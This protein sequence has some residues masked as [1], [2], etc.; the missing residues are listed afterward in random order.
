MPGQCQSCGEHAVI[1]AEIDG[2]GTKYICVECG[3]VDSAYISLEHSSLNGEIE[4][5][6]ADIHEEV[7]ESCGVSLTPAAL[8][9]RQQLCPDCASEEEESLEQPV[10][11]EIYVSSDEKIKLPLAGAVCKSCGSQDLSTECIGAD[12]RCVCKGCGTVIEEQ[13]LV[14]TDFEYSNSKAPQ[15]HSLTLPKHAMPQR[16]LKGLVAGLNKIRLLHDRFCFPD[17]VKTEADFMYEKVFFQKEVFFAYITTKEH[18]AAACLFLACRMQNIPISVTHFKPYLDKFSAF[19]KGKKLI[20]RLLNLQLPSVVQTSHV[21]YCLEGKGFDACLIQ[22]VND[23][24]FLCR[25]AWLTEGRSRPGLIAI[26]A[27]YAY[28][29]RYGAQGYMTLEKF[30]KKFKFPLIS[31]QLF[32]DCKQLFL[33]LATVLPWASSVDNKNLYRYIDDILRYRHSV[34]QLAFRS[35]V[36][37]AVSKPT[38]GTLSPGKRK[39]D[40]SSKELNLPISLKRIKQEKNYFTNDVVIP[41]HLNL[42][43]PEVRETDFDEEEINSYL[44]SN[45]EQE[46]VRL[47]KLEQIE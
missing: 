3:T 18:Y 4:R 28:L 27:Y 19:F 30:Q 26:A 6:E 39:S 33:K 1:E 34:F 41:P 11:A 20:V 40:E 21:S 36:D 31:V 29:S 13:R 42:N 14:S 44:L 22:K 8:E 45:E 23:I 12:E 46:K 32:N 25:N 24:L 17:S 7:C 38:N 9:A 15:N 2:E 37:S 35:D 16:K 5:E 43:D 47:L 10:P